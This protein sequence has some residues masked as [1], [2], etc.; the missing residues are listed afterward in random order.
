EFTWR[1]ERPYENGRDECVSFQTSEETKDTALRNPSTRQLVT[2]SLDKAGR[3]VIRMDKNSFQRNAGKTVED[4]DSKKPATNVFRDLIPKVLKEIKLISEEESGSAEDDEHNQQ[5]NKRK[6]AER[7][8][9]RE[10]STRYVQLASVSQR[11][12]GVVTK[13]II[14]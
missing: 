1:S 9:T 2:V 4:L 11:L 8:S 14:W 3:P 12:H 13:L 10:C 6:S 7:T 5:K